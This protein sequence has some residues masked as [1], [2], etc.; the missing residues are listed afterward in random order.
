MDTTYKGLYMSKLYRYFLPFALLSPCVALSAVNSHLPSLNHDILPFGSSF[1]GSLALGPDW[2]SGG[3]TQTLNLG[4]ELDKTYTANQPDNTIA[5]LDIFLGLQKSLTRCLTG[6]LGVD[7]ATTSEAKLSGNIWDDALPAFNNYTY[8]YKIK[9]TQL[10][11][12]GKLL[13]DFGWPVIPW[14]SVMMGVGF[15]ESFDFSNT[16]LLF[17]AVPSPNFSNNTEAAFTYGVGIG[18]QRKLVKHWQIGV[19]YEWSD[20]GRS[21]LGSVA[22]AETNQSITL[23]HFYASAVMLNITFLAL[24]Q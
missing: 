12:K 15:N 10:A 17:E 3:R 22:T 19:G 21:Q 13:A 14:V 9:H 16:P 11:L 23:S 4:P 20:W 6:Q 18:V 5:N 8:Q 7:F 1:V 2:V 24:D